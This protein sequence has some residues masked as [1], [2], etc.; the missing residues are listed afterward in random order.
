M[1]HRSRSLAAAAIALGALGLPAT[2]LAGRGALLHPAAAHRTASRAVGKLPV[3]TAVA[4]K[5]L[6]VGQTLRLRGRN[7]VV[8]A[9]ANTVV[10]SRAGGRY[11]FVK[12]RLASARHMW[13][14]IPTRLRSSLRVRSGARVA[15]RFRLRVLSHR[16]AAHFTSRRLSPVVV[17]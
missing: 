17:P 3:I 16:F 13:V 10:F 6:A 9:R 7:F 4:P 2:A 15:T 11:V 12:A 1:R 14:T 5:R 8:G